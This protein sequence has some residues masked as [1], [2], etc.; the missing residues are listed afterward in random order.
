[1]YNTNKKCRNTHTY[2]ILA[3]EQTNLFSKF[4]V[5]LIHQ[6]SSLDL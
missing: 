3:Y 1:M 5:L 2:N 6:H 4:A